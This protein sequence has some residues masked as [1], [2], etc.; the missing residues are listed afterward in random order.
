MLK[1]IPA[2]IL[3]IIFMLTSCLIPV[4]AVDEMVVTF[5][6]NGGTPAQ[7]V[8]PATNN[9]VALPSSPE[10][11]GYIFTGWNTNQN[12]SGSCFSADS[13]VNSSQVVYAQWISKSYTVYVMGNGG[14][15]EITK[16]YGNAEGTI[17]LPIPT[18]PGYRF[19]K[20]NASPD[21]FGQDFSSTTPVTEE[22][23]VFALW[24]EEEYDVTFVN[25]LTHTELPS[26]GSIKGIKQFP[27]YLSFFDLPFSKIL[28]GWH[29]N[30]GNSCSG[31]TPITANTTLTSQLGNSDTVVYFFGNGGSPQRQYIPYNTANGLNHSPQT[32]TRK[33]YDFAGWYMDVEGTVPFNSETVIASEPAAVFAKW[34]KKT[35][36]YVYF[37]DNGKD[38]RVY[39]REGTVD[40]IINFPSSP[41][42][43]VVPFLGW[44]LNEKGE[45]DP[46]T[47]NNRITGTTHVYSFF[48]QPFLTY[49]WNDGTPRVYVSRENP[50]Q[51][52]PQRE[53]FNFKGWYTDLNATGTPVT[54]NDF[55]S[56]TNLY[57]GW[58]A[59]Y[60]AP[61][62]QNP[63]AT[64]V[65]PSDYTQSGQE[66]L[67][68]ISIAKFYERAIVPTGIKENY[69]FL[70][71]SAG[72]DRD[73]DGQNAFLPDE[74]IHSYKD[75]TLTAVC[76]KVPQAADYPPPN[77]YSNIDKSG[78]WIFSAV[79][80]EYDPD[81]DVR[82][83]KKVQ[84]IKYV[85]RS[86]SSVVMPT[87]VTAVIN[88]G[89]SQ[90]EC[91]A[92]V[93]GYDTNLFSNN[94]YITSVTLTDL[95]GNQIPLSFFKNCINL[96][97]VTLSSNIETV[98][99]WAFENCFSLTD[100]T[101]LANV[102]TVGDGT[103]YNCRS[104]TN[105]IP[106]E[107][108]TSV[109]SNA[110]YFSG[111]TE[112]ALKSSAGQVIIGSEAFAYC[113][114]L[115]DF[116]AC[117]GTEIGA[118][119]FRNCPFVA[120]D[121]SGT[122]K[123]GAYAFT[124][125]QIYAN[126]FTLPDTL[127][128]LGEGAFADCYY[129]QS[130]QLPDSIGSIDYIPARAFKNCYQLQAVLIPSHYQSIGTEAF[131]NCTGLRQFQLDRP[132][133]AYQDNPIAIGHAALMNCC[134]LTSDQLILA[135]FINS[136]SSNV[137][138]ECNR[139][140]YIYYQQEIPPVV[141]G[142][143]EQLYDHD[144]P[145]QGNYNYYFKIYYP[146]T[147]NSAANWSAVKPQYAYVK[148]VRLFNLFHYDHTY[149][150]NK[151][152]EMDYILLAEAKSD[153]EVFKYQKPQP[154]KRF[155]GWYADAA[156]QTPISSVSGE[157]GADFWVPLPL[158]EGWNGYPVAVTL[159]AAY[160]AEPIT[161]LTTNV[162]GTLDEP[163]PVFAT[164]PFGRKYVGWDAEP[165]GMGNVFISLQSVFNKDA[166][167]YPKLVEKRYRMVFLGNG[168]TPFV[169][170]GIGITTDEYQPGDAIISFP[171]LPQRAG[172][173]F[174]GWAD[175][176]GTPVNDTTRIKNLKLETEG[177]IEYVFCFAQWEKNAYNVTFDPAG[178]TLQTS[179][180]LADIDGLQS[181]NMP[182]PVKTGFVF[183]GFKLDNSYV[184][185]DFGFTRNVSLTAQ[186]E[187]RKGIV[188]FNSGGG[189][190]MDCQFVPLES[191]FN[192][193]Q[194]VP[195]RSDDTFE[196]WYK[197]A[198]L[199]HKWDNEE[200]IVPENIVLF[201]KWVGEETG[202]DNCF[203]A[204]AAFGS[205]YA[206]AVKLL[207]TFRDDYLLT[208]EPGRAFVAFYYCHSPVMATYIA[209]HEGL[210][211]LTRISLSPIIAFVYL[212]YHKWLMVL[213]VMMFIFSRR[214]KGST[215]YSQ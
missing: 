122:T 60:L 127:V 168:G 154:G 166:I 77:N 102:L 153:P 116:S 17:N 78:Q 16:L 140:S 105:W 151:L 171:Q 111:L 188:F 143:Y 124:A 173:T 65:V 2:L 131:R 170:N 198:A 150:E 9:K 103:F 32:P 38:P 106:F 212:L 4:G 215:R 185:P 74:W 206:P 91:Q 70:Y 107:K 87:T 175:S 93:S 8:V 49:N 34:I 137:F 195:V 158:Y 205:L 113:K 10:R 44:Y 51:V 183:T 162:Q 99:S 148:S 165:Y 20:F 141:D 134:S 72:N 98:S 114:K 101:G 30:Q 55:R 13:V 56:E 203:I 28:T 15:P 90:F 52:I 147:S 181:A 18:R 23:S 35:S 89:D 14:S 25:S 62:F 139:L 24:E 112:V 149:T 76:A 152:A 208:N 11:D 88:A 164:P 190:Q 204:T 199:Q 69:T 161:A 128:E 202:G 214:I 43:G 57:A 75:M 174:K 189:N 193:N 136:L 179:S 1:K 79:E 210:K 138:Y 132:V 117:P 50:E 156:C 155:S 27:D 48:G 92:E 211:M 109:G 33:H 68:Q 61:D 160:G 121:L 80:D 146:Y 180:A 130:V 83:P 39:T 21:G 85:S 157:M 67:S 7:T 201:A 58:E 207:R 197:D 66:Y 29:D 119:A 42:L 123:I 192:A 26:K 36:Y 196:G 104:Y 187:G 135:R 118:Y 213:L 167:I 12:G 31:Q 100:V 82:V 182:V 176:N 46:I 3:A 94:S 194:I 186:W 142:G 73:A 120:C 84:L 133:S 37:H 5:N 108:A 96:Q 178:G 200:D 86:Q 169:T 6:G 144:N 71:W 209:D 45:G 97:T 41:G 172:Y 40:G 59:K 110:F 159:K 184:S 177:G 81:H 125:S 145:M 22:I 126:N 19:K 129:M 64:F 95:V 53:G 163:L 115:T 191:T 54:S 63:V 47:E